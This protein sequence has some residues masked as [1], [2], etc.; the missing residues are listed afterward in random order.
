MNRFFARIT[1]IYLLFVIVGVRTVKAQHDP[2]AALT[3]AVDKFGVHL[4]YPAHWTLIA[5]ENSGAILL[6]PEVHPPINREWF[7]HGFAVEPFPPPKYTVED[8]NI[9]RSGD[10]RRIVHRIFDRMNDG[11]QEAR[12]VTEASTNVAGVEAY[13]ISYELTPPSRLVS[14]RKEE[15]LLIVP[16]PKP[17]ETARCF[18]L[19]A[20]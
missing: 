4:E 8:Y 19:F 18:H 16:Q 5:P 17:G 20:H 7:T 1:T 6:F 15:G 9:V 12:I 2:E 10:A 13:Y 11:K 14:A 3:E